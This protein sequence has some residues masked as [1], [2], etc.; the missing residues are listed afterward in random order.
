MC[1]RG[2]VAVD[3]FFAEPKDTRVLSH[4]RTSSARST[5]PERCFCTW[6]ALRPRVVHPAPATTRRAAARADDGAPLDEPSKQHVFEQKTRRASCM[7]TG[8]R[9]STLMT[10][11]A[12][13]L[14]VVVRR[15]SVSGALP[16]A[17]TSSVVGRRSADGELVAPASSIRLVL[18]HELAPILS[19]EVAL[20][21]AVSDAAGPL[22]RGPDRRTRARLLRSSGHC[23]A[24]SPLH[25]RT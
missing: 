8:G 15:P 7:K 6:S 10:P 13:R 20:L 23:C 17:S 14:R 5:E 9:R 2:D 18:R 22:S 4:R 3:F 21:H 16:R 11:A 12:G 19:D 25:A 1:R 24:H